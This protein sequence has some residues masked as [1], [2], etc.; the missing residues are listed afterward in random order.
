[1]I[2]A[3]T[4]TFGPTFAVTVTPGASTTTLGIWKY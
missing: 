2:A 3:S 4:G 1:L